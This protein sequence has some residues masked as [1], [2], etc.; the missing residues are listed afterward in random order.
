M[1]VSGQAVVGVGLLHAGGTHLAA[2]L[3]VA[4]D[5]VGEVDGVEDL[6]AAE[7]GDLYGSRAR[8]AGY[9]VRRGSAWAHTTWGRIGVRAITRAGRAF[10]R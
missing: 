8:H 5:G 2:L 4:G 10:E 6:G 3:A 9:G 7:S 1:H